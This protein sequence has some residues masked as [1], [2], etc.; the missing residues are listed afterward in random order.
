MSVS[1]ATT[2]GGG[3]SS[4]NPLCC[5]LTSRS[6]EPC[7]KHIQHAGTYFCRHHLQYTGERVPVR[8]QAANAWMA[9]QAPDAEEVNNEPSA[10]A[11]RPSPMAR[12]AAM[13]LPPSPPRQRQY[14]QPSGSA[15]SGISRPP[16]PPPQ[17]A[18]EQVPA[19]QQHQATGY[20]VS[21]ALAQHGIR[22]EHGILKVPHK[23]GAASAMLRDIT[24]R[25][26]VP[27]EFVVLPPAAHR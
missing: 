25:V 17:V 23:L 11:S 16:P 24:S 12:Y 1:A 22:F 7:R 26:G 15:M 10:A 21:P 20:P 19:Q 6:K 3:G 13:P 14:Q 8:V 4:Q 2:Q 18:V 27:L 9:E 5:A